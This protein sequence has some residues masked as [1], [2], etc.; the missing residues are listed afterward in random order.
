MWLARESYDARFT[1]PAARSPGRK[2]KAVAV[3]LSSLASIPAEQRPQIA[4]A[5]LSAVA[6][7]L[8]YEVARVPDGITITPRERE[9]SA[10]DDKLTPERRRQA[11]AAGIGVALDVYETDAGEKTQLRRQRIV[12]PLDRLWKAGVLSSDEF[13][14]ARRYQR[15]CDMAAVSGP[16]MAVSYAPRMIQG[17]GQR[18]LLPLEAQQEHQRRLVAAQAACGPALRRMLVWIADEP[19]SWRKQAKLWFP[20]ASERAAREMFKRNLTLACRCLDGHYRRK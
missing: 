12:S 8:A 18:L 4:R 13:G 7:P 10:A 5:R 15:D 19:M 2:R 3:T 1:M 16:S 17:G 11:A 14:A 9:R 6:R 20:S